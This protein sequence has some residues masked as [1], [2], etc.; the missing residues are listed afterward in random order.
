MS[1]WRR[2]FRGP[3]GQRVGHATGRAGR[4]TFGRLLETLLP[5]S[6]RVPL[7]EVRE[8]RRVLLVRPNF[9][10][11]NTL[12]TNSI[13]P[14]LRE[15]FPGARLE[16]LAGD[17]T[18]ALLEN[19][20][21]DAVHPMSRSYVGKPWEFVEL[22]RRLRRERFDVA[23][24]AGMGSFSGGL[25][26]W[27]TGARFRIGFE[28][29]G[30]RFLNVLLPRPTCMHAY[31]DALE[32]GAALGMEVADRPVYEVGEDE[33]AAAVGLL[34]GL[35]LLDA[36][37]VRPFVAVF[38]GGHLHKR[39]PNERWIRFVREIDRAGVAFVVF[40]GPEEAALEHSFREQAGENGRV[41]PPGPL[42]LFAAVLA[43]AAV[44]VTPDSGPMHLGVALGVPTIAF[45]QNEDSR[46]YEPRGEADR[47]VVAPDVRDALEVVLSHP[48]VRRI[49]AEQGSIGHSRV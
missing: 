41:L 14:G 22:F 23:V 18:L 24:E 32:I 12:M 46:F 8:V 19:M 20:S 5:R 28:G 4:Q 33:R 9:R 48:A 44:L 38:V 7:G 29:S 43:R 16:Y 10:L 3:G 39:W 1:L 31:D 47:A 26:S 45:L 35:G 25:Y 6:A 40:L 17:T 37:V 15:R 13:V 34:E 49:L 27:L 11:G 36:G 2:L 21:I 30:E 42:R